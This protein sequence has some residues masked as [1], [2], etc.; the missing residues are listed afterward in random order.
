[1]NENTEAPENKRNIWMRALFMLLMGIAFQVCGTL[2]CI[3]TIVQ[4]VIML[5]N[6]TPNKR[7]VAFGR[8]LGNYLRQIVNFLIFATEEMPF[9]FSE[10]PAAE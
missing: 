6:D 1:M 2:L 7:L 10:W 8:S 3:V 5:L 4:F 9:P